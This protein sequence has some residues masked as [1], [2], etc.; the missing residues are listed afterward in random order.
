[1]TTQFIMPTNV[2]I[3]PHAIR[4][5]GSLF[6]NFGKKA[7]LV[8][9]KTMMALG[10]CNELLETL[11][12]Y[13]IDFVLD[14]EINGE[15]TDIMIENGVAKFHDNNCDFIISLGGGSCIDAMKAIAMMCTSTH[16][17]R[18]M[19]QQSFTN[20]RPSMIAIPTT[21][22]TGSEA[23][24]FTII[25]DTKNEVKMLLKGPKLIPDLAII[26]PLLTLSLPKQVTAITGIDALCHA[27]EAFTSRKSQSLSDTMALD[28]ISKIFKYLPVCYNDPSNIEART[29][30]ALAAFTAGCA[31]NNSSV[32]LVH[33]MSRPIG[34]L[35]HVAHGLSNAILI[36]ACLK[37]VQE[38]IQ[39]KLNQI[40]Q[41]ADLTDDFFTALHKLLAILNIPTLKKVILDHDLFRK[42]IDKMAT[43]AMISGSPKNTI[44]DIDKED[45]IKIYESLINN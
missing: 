24:Q 28:A 40:V 39:D 38:P 42:K 16:S 25:T 8:T 20:P 22:G 29:Q 19:M 32:T 27:V 1:M 43:D 11:S 12:T 10:T 2:I 26:D 4:D 44:M 21:A 36:E 9:D 5:N 31:F 30:M 18:D 3:G 14:D 35:F 15:P 6:L 7:L 41:S 45:L 37:Y 33:G 13:Q 17:I 34:A 23:T